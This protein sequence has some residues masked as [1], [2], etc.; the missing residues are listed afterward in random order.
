MKSIMFLVGIV[1]LSI[2]SI[3]VYYFVALHKG[4]IKDEDKNFVPDAVDSTAQELK[5]KA[6]K[7]KKELKDV[8][9]AITGNNKK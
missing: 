1:L 2:V 9:D 6:K 4:D 7:V 5:K 8:A 3:V